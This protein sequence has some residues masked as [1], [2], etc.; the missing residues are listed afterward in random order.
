MVICKIDF[1][2]KSLIVG[3]GLVFVDLGA[4]KAVL[5]G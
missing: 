5:C 4:F 2:G 3:T 1:A